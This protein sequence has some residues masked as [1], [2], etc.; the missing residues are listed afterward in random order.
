MHEQLELD[1]AHNILKHDDFLAALNH[2]V[3]YWQT[4]YYDWRVQERLDEDNQTELLAAIDFYKD[5][6]RKTCL[7]IIMRTDFEAGSFGPNYT[8]ISIASGLSASQQREL[9]NGHPRSIDPGDLPLELVVDAC[10]TRANK[11]A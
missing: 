10:I 3:A 5:Y 1:L 2:I 11:Y 9:A 6:G 8:Y 4:V 7:E